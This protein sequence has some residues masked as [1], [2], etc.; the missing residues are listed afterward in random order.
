MILG[1]EA[2]VVDR[3]SRPIN[4]KRNNKKKRQ[5]K[6]KLCFK[7]PWCLGDRRSPLRDLFRIS[8]CEINPQ[9]KMPVCER[10]AFLTYFILLSSFLSLRSVLLFLASDSLFSCGLCPHPHAF[11]KKR[12]KN[13]CAYPKISFAFLANFSPSASRTSALSSSL[14]SLTNAFAPR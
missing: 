2:T 3:N 6:T 8:H 10:F 12:G 1:S 9:N 11:C 7:P 13:F 14:A 4:A 5:F